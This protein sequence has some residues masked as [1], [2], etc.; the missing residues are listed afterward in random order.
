MPSDK[1]RVISTTL[2]SPSHKQTLYEYAGARGLRSL[3]DLVRVALWEYLRRHKPAEGSELRR[4][5]DAMLR[6]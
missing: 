5:I 2:D 4:R 3:G 6:E 1:Q